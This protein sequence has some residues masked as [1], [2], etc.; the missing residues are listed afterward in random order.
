[1]SVALGLLVSTSPAGSCAEASQ[2]PLPSSGPVLPGRCDWLR[3]RWAPILCAL[4]SPAGVIGCEGSGLLGSGCCPL[5]QV[6]AGAQ[7][8]GSH[9]WLPS[10]GWLSGFCVRSQ[11]SGSLH[12]C[13]SLKS[14]ALRTSD[15]SLLFLGV[16]VCF[17]STLESGAE[18]KQCLSPPSWTRNTSS[19][20]FSVKTE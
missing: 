12:S 5:G 14:L 6:R 11:P 13:A 19:L 2:Q 18:S 3:G 4:S 15:V 10:G 9:P 17:P 20:F 8:V 7:K 16:H 1:M